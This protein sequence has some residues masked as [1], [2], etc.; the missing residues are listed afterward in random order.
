[1]D[2]MIKKFVSRNKRRLKEDGY[3]LDLTYIVPNIIAMGFPSDKLEGYYRNHIEDV[4]KFLEDHHRDR[5]KIYNL[6]SERSYDPSK[7]HHRVAN[8][9]F[10]D[11]NPPKLELIKPFCEDLDDWLSKHP[12]NVAAIHCKAGKGRTGV[13]ICAYLLHRQ[14]FDCAATAL[15][16]YGK[17]RTQDGKGVTI[18][19]QRRYVL[20]Y[21]D[22]LKPGA[23]YKEVNLLLRGIKFY[24]IPMFSGGTCV[25]YFE[26]H[27]MKVLIYSSPAYESVRKDMTDVYMPVIPTPVS[28]DI[29]IEFFHKSK[30]NKKVRC[31]ILNDFL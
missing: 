2:N 12:D 29:K 1:M 16:Y 15:E 4:I 11:H 10:D 3:D 30:I 9:P 26:V 5:Y 24:T 23:K 18:P 8:Y 21:D 27:K 31:P 19:S 22:L 13:M 6:C 17:T 28:G 20:Y 14:R 7:F 25:P